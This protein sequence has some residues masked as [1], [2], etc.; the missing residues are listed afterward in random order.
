MIGV[1]E[2]SGS[3]IPKVFSVWRD[4]NWETPHFEEEFNPDRT[5]LTL[6]IKDAHVSIAN[7][8]GITGG[9]NGGTKKATVLAV[10]HENAY[11]TINEIAIATGL[12]KRTVE[13]VI[14]SLKE[15]NE[16]KRTGPNKGGCWEVLSSIIEGDTIGR[17]HYLAAINKNEI[18]KNKLTI[19]LVGDTFPRKV[20]SFGQTAYRVKQG[21]YYGIRYN[22]D[23]S[24]FE[25]EG[26][27]RLIALCDSC[28]FFRS[29]ENEK[30]YSGCD[31][32][33]IIKPIP[34]NRV[35]ISF[36][37]YDNGFD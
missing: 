7:G 10:L 31:T 36:K 20:E 35:E 37:H 19:S 6:P 16:I 23:Y 3:G 21:A 22:G 29:Q 5:I 9:T 18:E 32:C 11:L 28:V 25:T 13:R 17:D 24:F 1:G 34:E 27:N 12:G 15:T 14:K 2:R 30:P 33:Y 26:M 8:G 4:E